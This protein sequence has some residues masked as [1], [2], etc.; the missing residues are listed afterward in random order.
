[1]ASPSDGVE[2]LQAVQAV[3]RSPDHSQP[4]GIFSIR[5]LAWV[6]RRA[7]ADRSR[8]RSVLVEAFGL[9]RH[10]CGCDL[11]MRTV[12]GLVERGFRDT[13]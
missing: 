12:E 2:G 9:S 7:G 3:A 6:I 10:R 11:A 1:M 8:K 4:G 5:R 13:P